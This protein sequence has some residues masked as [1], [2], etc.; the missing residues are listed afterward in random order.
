ML[1]NRGNGKQIPVTPVLDVRPL[2]EQKLLVFADFIRL[3]AYGNNKFAWQSP[4][5]CWDELK[6]TNVTSDVI[7]GTGYDPTNS[8]TQESH[9]TVDVKDWSLLA[10]VAQRNS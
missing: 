7:E 2:L 8:V 5:V 4:R 9:F 10:S 6:I 1:S 3:A